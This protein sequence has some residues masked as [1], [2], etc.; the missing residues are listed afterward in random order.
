MWR[1]T[2][3]NRG[4]EKEE[5]KNVDEEEEV[6]I[7]GGV[8]DKTSINDSGLDVG[9]KSIAESGNDDQDPTQVETPLYGCC[10]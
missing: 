9:D 7:G 1:R 5:E 4:K 6:E 8:R 3:Q 10:P 2:R